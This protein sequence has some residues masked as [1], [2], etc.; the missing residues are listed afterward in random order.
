MYYHHCYPNKNQSNEAF[1]NIVITDR[2]IDNNIMYN[3]KSNL[4]FIIAY[5]YENKYHTDF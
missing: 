2:V 5:R 3:I 4:Y 1:N